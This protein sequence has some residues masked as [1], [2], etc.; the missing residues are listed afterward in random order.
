MNSEGTTMAKKTRKPRKARTP[1]SSAEMIERG[2]TPEAPPTIEQVGSFSG[3]MQSMTDYNARTKTKTLQIT[4]A[5]SAVLE[6]LAL[7]LQVQSQAIMHLATIANT[8]PFHNQT[9]EEKQTPFDVQ[10]P[11]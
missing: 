2:L 5:R 8:A 10:D 3:F 7:T 9:F 11:A 4:D 1:N 6:Q